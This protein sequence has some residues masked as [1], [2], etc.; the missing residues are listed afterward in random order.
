VFVAMVSR[1]H[2]DLSRKGG[3]SFR[4]RA[5]GTY[6][7]WVQVRDENPASADDG[8]EWWFTSVKTSPGWR[9]IALPF[10]ELR[11]INPRTDGQLDLDVVRSI[12]FAIDKGAMPPGSEGVIWIDDVGAYE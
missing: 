2:R 4:M 11:S 10:A 6:R 7:M 8:T 3:L 9:D 1:E 12:V 5:D